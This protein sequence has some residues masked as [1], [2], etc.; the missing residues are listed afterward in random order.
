LGE[1]SHGPVDGEGQFEKPQG[2]D[3]MFEHVGDF[4]GSH[5]HDSVKTLKLYG[6]G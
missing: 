2:Q 4:A 5:G 3:G 1:A 6:A